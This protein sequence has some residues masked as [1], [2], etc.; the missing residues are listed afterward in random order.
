MSI[1]K[2]EVDKD[3]FKSFV[4][5]FY[6]RYNV[7]KTNICD[8]MIIVPSQQSAKFLKMAFLDHSSTLL[9]KIYSISNIANEEIISYLA[10]KSMFAEILQFRSAINIT[11]QKLFVR[12]YLN[13]LNDQLIPSAKHMENFINQIVTTINELKKHEISFNKLLDF[14]LIDLPIHLEK[15]Y[16]ILVETYEAWNEYLIINKKFDE[17]DLRNFRIKTLTNFLSS[18]SPLKHITIAGSTGSQEITTE[19]ILSMAKVKNCDVVLYGIE[20]LESD[21]LIQENHPF[22]LIDKLCKRLKVNPKNISPYQNSAEKNIINKFIGEVF[23]HPSEISKWNNHS[24]IVPQN[25]KII[26]TDDQFEEINIIRNI[27]KESILKNPNQNIL[28]LSNSQSITNNL[29]ALLKADYIFPINSN[30]QS[31]TC[32]NIFLF[33]KLIFEVILR[34]SDDMALILS[35]LKNEFTPSIE[36][37]DEIEI[38]LLRGHKI[39]NLWQIINLISKH[40]MNDY[41]QKLLEIF[42]TETDY[43]E[44]NILALLKKHIKIAERISQSRIWEGEIGNYF[45]NII[46][47]LLRNPLINVTDKNYFE[48]ITSLLADFSFDSQDIFNPNIL[49]MNSIEARLYRADITII[50]D[51]NESTWP[52][53]DNINFPIARPIKEKL[54]LPNEN[55]RI[56]QQAFDL[57]CH[58]HAKQVYITRS[59][60]NSE[61]LL[62]QSRWLTRIKLL[63]K[64]KNCYQQ[65]LEFEKIRT[66]KDKYLVDNK[67]YHLPPNPNPPIQMRPVRYSATDLEKLMQDPYYIYCSKILKLK[68]LDPINKPYSAV[69][70]GNLIHDIF[71]KISSGQKVKLEEYVAKNI[72]DPF[73]AKLWTPRIQKAANWIT[74]HNLELLSDGNTLILSEHK[75][76]NNYSVNGIPIEIVCK[77]DRIEINN[78][79]VKIIDYKTGSIPTNSDIK[80]FFA[81]QLQLGALSFVENNHNIVNLSY[82]AIK[83]GLNVVTSHDFITKDYKNLNEFVMASK[84]HV[85]NLIAQYLKPVPYCAQVDKKLQLTYN[86]FQ[87]LTRI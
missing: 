27:I 42:G 26:E 36:F 49:I 30:P 6:H 53:I 46:Y 64:K 80:C 22:Y 25:L 11:E 71:E 55:I 9:P 28:V 19:L 63:A 17:V 23:R 84:E 73:L 12:K 15:A 61:G 51:F 82:F 41:A 40:G 52:H 48:I 43:K 29:L 87:H 34:K 76:V 62:E 75:I 57:Y 74:Q 77:T 38:K 32:S 3:F 83:T 20:F 33:L 21:H 72:S 4:N 10:S 81:L 8:Y 65:I 1:F 14:D 24:N 7:N 85:L 18:H 79:E 69:D 54:G 70:Y 31:L 68:Q 47:D 50:A 58:A 59:N 67:K 45:S 16:R 78:N 60:R 2:I 37:I 13:K 44:N 56:G 66:L 5:G 39:G 86:H 35:L